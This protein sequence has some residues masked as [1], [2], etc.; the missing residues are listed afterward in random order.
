M[1]SNL[2]AGG[3]VEAAILGGVDRIEIDPELFVAEGEA[4][5]VDVRQYYEFAMS[6]QVPKRRG[7]I[8]ERRPVPD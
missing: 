1:Y 8:G 6:F 4:L 5:V 7:E 3:F 2:R